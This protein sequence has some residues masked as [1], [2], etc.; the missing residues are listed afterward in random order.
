MSSTENEIVLS[1]NGDTFFI[2]IAP[3]HARCIC[4]LKMRFAETENSLSS[5]PKIFTISDEAM[6]DLGSDEIRE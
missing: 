3:L 1:S 6:I 2:A 4:I 5:A